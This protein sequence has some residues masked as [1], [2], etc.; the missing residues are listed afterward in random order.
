MRLKHISCVLHTVGIGPNGRGIML[1]FRPRS[2]GGARVMT[3]VNCN[4]L[5]LLVVV[6]VKIRVGGHGGASTV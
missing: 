3:C 1:S 6:N 2:L 5:M 4:I